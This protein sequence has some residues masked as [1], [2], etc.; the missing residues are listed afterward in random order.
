MKD[1]LQI[2]LKQKNSL[3]TEDAW[4]EAWKT[5]HYKIYERCK[6]FFIKDTVRIHDAL[7]NLGEV[8]LRRKSSLSFTGNPLA[9]EEVLGILRYAAGTQHGNST[10]RTYASG[11]ALYPI[12]I[13][14]INRLETK[15]FL[16]GVYHFNP[17]DNSFSYIKKIPEYSSLSELIGS[18]YT[19]VDNASGII[20]F[21]AVPHRTTDKY[22]WLGIRTCFFDIGQIIQN[23]SLLAEALGF[24]YRPIAGFSNTLVDEM[25]HIDENTETSILVY[26]IGT[27]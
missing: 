17:K 5:V 24:S 23:I 25:L 16:S 27:R 12:E 2:V 18:P 6:T 19:M 13:Y 26:G 1:L 4:P 22:G 15:D 3:P 8:L 14:Y 7:G 21:T 20:C 10:H 9:L 11:G